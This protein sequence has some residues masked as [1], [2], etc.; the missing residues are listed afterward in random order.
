[1]AFVLPGQSGENK[2]AAPALE[3]TVILTRMNA[4]KQ[5]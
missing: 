5:G 4:D 2:Q 3:T 1:M